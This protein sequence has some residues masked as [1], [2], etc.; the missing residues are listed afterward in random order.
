[1]TDLDKSL[2]NL[3]FNDDD[4]VLRHKKE[5]KELQ[6]KIQVLKKTAGKG[7]KKKKKEILEE[8]ARLE[9]DLEKRHADEL[10]KAETTTVNG[11]NHSNEEDA[12]KTNIYRE[13]SISAYSSPMW[14]LLLFLFRKTKTE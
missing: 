7:D 13:A 3:S 11:V 1:M 2:E 8:I 12:K 10:A 14:L 9:S 5:R 4:L 6:A